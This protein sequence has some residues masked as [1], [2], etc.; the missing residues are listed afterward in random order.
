[1]KHHEIKAHVSAVTGQQVF[2]GRDCVEVVIT[3][4]HPELIPIVAKKLED[5]GLSFDQSRHR[6][7]KGCTFAIHIHNVG[8]TFNADWV[9]GKG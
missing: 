3:G 2:D 9:F 7:F 4:D 1:M 5:A 8:T 6:K